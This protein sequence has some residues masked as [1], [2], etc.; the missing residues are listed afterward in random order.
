[1]GWSF[2][3]VAFGTPAYPVITTPVTIH[4]PAEGADAAETTGVIAADSLTPQRTQGS[5][6]YSR[7]DA[8]RFAALGDAVRAHVSAAYA[9]AVDQRCLTPTP[10]AA[11]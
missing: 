2:P 1:M 5:L 7:E 11:C 4:T 9:S 6:R 10:P 8:A 3:R